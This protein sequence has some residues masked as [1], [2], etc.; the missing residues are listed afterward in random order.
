MEAEVGVKPVILGGL[1]AGFTV[2]PL[3]IDA[4]SLPVVMDTVR[5]PAEALASTMIFAVATVELL[6]V[7]EFT[8][9]LTPKF[10]LLLPCTKCV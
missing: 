9:T 2:N 3:A 4:V 8:V 5:V 1:D 10:A 6:A 7:S